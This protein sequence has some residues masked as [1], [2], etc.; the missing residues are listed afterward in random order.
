MLEENGTGQ[1]S[2][3]FRSTLNQ[4]LI[5]TEKCFKAR[6]MI[7]SYITAF[8]ECAEQNSLIRTEPGFQDVCVGLNIQ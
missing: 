3:M 8:I 5:N 6:K 1:L 2:G 4:Q 7:R